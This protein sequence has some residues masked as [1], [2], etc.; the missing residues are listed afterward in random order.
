M[1]TRL[2]L[3]A[4]AAVALTVPAAHAQSPANPDPSAVKPGVYKIE[5][6]H[7]RVLFSVS[8][9]GFTTWY[10]D[11][12][13]VSGQLT[14]DPAHPGA[15]RLEVTLPVASVTTTNAKLDGEL[16]AADWLDAARYPTATFRSTAITA[17][18]PR[19]A[20]IA[21]LLTLHGVTR[22]VTLHAHFNGAGVNPITHGYTSGF[23][24]T[25]VIHRSA[26][27]V[28]K[29]VPLIGDDVTLTISAA[30]EKAAG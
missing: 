27:G 29:Y 8:H 20:D 6:S 30:F 24:V 3:A 7:T 5:P 25:G 9:M 12:S 10:G 22:P 16:K 26:F 4:L 11:F 14:L 21:G 19:D 23:E 28:T 1:S 13:D 15:S 18:G 17:T 2:T